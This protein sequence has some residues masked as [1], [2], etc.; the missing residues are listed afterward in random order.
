MEKI[1][2]LLLALCVC[3]SLCACGTTKNETPE[4]TEPKSIELTTENISQYLNIVIGEVVDTGDSI[5]TTL[6]E[7]YPLQPGDFTNVEIVLSIKVDNDF[8]LSSAIGATLE[9]EE[10]SEH[11]GTL[12]FKLPVDGRHKIDIKLWDRLGWGDTHD[13]I[14]EYTF[15]SVSGTFI[16]NN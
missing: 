14:Y 6:I 15:T 8:E 11:K 9:T 7:F 5:D 3:F 1:I 13:G 2:A 10:E 12:T 4:T 16:P